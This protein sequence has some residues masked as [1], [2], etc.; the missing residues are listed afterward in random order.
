MPGTTFSFSLYLPIIFI[1][2]TF[3]SF[4]PVDTGG[5]LNVLCTF[6]LPPVST[7][8]LPFATFMIYTIYH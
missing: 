7:G 2:Y 8:K 3:L 1:L 5:K 4:H 6:N